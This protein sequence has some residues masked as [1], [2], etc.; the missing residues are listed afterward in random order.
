[1]YNAEE[2]LDECIRSL[3][4]QSLRDCE[5][6]FVNDGS[7]DKSRIII[8]GYQEKDK[9]IKLVNQSNQGVSAARNA[10]LK[11]LTGEYVGFVDADD[12]IE[13]EMY[14]TLY[15]AASHK[16]C[17]AVIS[18]FESEL[19][20]NKL[21][22][23]YPFQ[24]DIQLNR[25]FIMDVIM[26]Y[27]L[28]HDNLNTVVSK[29]Y[30]SD[31]LIKCQINFPEKIALGEDGMFNILFFSH[32]L[33]MMYVDYTGYHYREVLGS[34]TRNIGEKDYFNQALEVYL[35]ATPD[36]YKEI[37]S[38][39]DVNRLKSIRLIN[40]VISYIYIYFKPNKEMS[41]KN[42]YHY[43]NRMI[44]N[45][46]VRAAIPDYRKEMSGSIGRYES[47]IVSMVKSRFTFGLLLA[48]TY[49]RLRNS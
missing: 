28:K 24:S 15:T 44:T 42:R 46:Y 29:I 30:R 6:I 10:A 9:R 13:K 12:F 33:T 1:M 3:L 16:N 27:F 38:V 21:L 14:Q 18:N 32:A 23:K 48:V 20:G 5:F 2:Y 31:L 11:I 4:N 22:T 37:M 8:E 49:S 39:K 19:E 17:D 40:S 7:I 36:I 41:L 43:V 35:A 26:P 47:Y 34:A 25:S 45:K